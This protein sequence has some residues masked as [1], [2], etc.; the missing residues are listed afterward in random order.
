MGIL[1]VVAT[2]IGNLEDISIRALRILFTADFVACED[3]RRAGILLSE[4]NKRYGAR[5]ALSKTDPKLIRYDDRTELNTTAEII[6]ILNQGKSIALISDA[7]TPLISDPGFLLVSHARKRGIKVESIPGASAV[8]TALTSSGLPADK[9]TFLGFPPERAQ[10]RIK[11][12]NSVARN[13]TIIFYCAPH[14]L[15]TTLGEMKDIFGDIEICL[16]RELT[17]IH[18]EVWNG[19]ITDALTHFQDPKGEFVVLFHLPS[20]VP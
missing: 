6:E 8:L 2:P 16:C 5:L 20:Y 17:K 12:F 18:E 15:I 9:F 11:F 7:G 4:L 13:Q 1:Y 14:K 19:S 10:H 3:T